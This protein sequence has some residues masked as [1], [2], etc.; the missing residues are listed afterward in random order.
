MA[1]ITIRNL[2]DD[3]HEAIKLAAE[4][5]GRSM[6]SELRVLIQKQYKKR[7]EPKGL[8]AALARFREETGGLT[9][10]ELKYLERD[11]AELP[12]PMTFD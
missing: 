9:D 8:L 12:K 11:E 3:L 10:D 4:S 6:E 1:N 2:D 7:G 5:N